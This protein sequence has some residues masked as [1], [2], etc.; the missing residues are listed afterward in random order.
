MIKAMMKKETYKA[1]DACR[2]NDETREVLKGL[3]ITEKH[4]EA[5]DGRMLFRVGRDHVGVSEETKPGVYSVIGVAKKD[6][7]GFAGY[8]EIA[9]EYQEGAE[10]P[11]TN[12]VI[13]EPGKAADQI[14]FTLE[15]ERK[16]PMSISAAIIKLY[17]KTG[18]AYAAHLLTRL[19]VLNEAWKADGAEKDKPA[20]LNNGNGY[21]AVI[22]PFRID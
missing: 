11:N 20:L 7:A 16:A 6:K 18:N 14:S 5:T 21:T 4:I 9:L 8:V 12:L 13:P 2:S 19:A 1:L 22:M 3:H 15:P 17:Q 10:Y